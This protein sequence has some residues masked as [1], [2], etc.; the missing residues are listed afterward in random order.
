M[1]DAIAANKRDSL[2][3]GMVQKSQE[4]YSTE[5]EIRK[6]GSRLSQE[7]TKK[8]SNASTSSDD[9]KIFEK[10]FGVRKQ[11]I[12]S[13]CIDTWWLKTIHFF[14]VFI[15][16]YISLMETAAT[17]VFVGYATQSYKQ[18][19]LMA[20]IGVIRAVVVA[21]SL[22]AFAR[23][24]DIFG[25]F[26]IFW[27]G[28][29]L[30]VIGLIIMSQATSVQKY[31]GGIVFYGAGFASARILLQ[32]SA[33][34][35]TT[36]RWRL[37]SNAV[38]SLPVIITTWSSG[39]VVSSLQERYGWHFGIAMWAFTV[40]LCCIPFGLS[41]L[42]AR[43]KAL[44]T[45]EWKLVI[46]EEKAS[47]VEL[48]PHREEYR[49]ALQSK[50]GFFARLPAHLKMCFHFTKYRVIQTFWQVD[51]LGCLLV[52]CMFGFIL[53]P[54]TLA[55]GSLTKWQRGSIIAP[56]VIG[57]CFIPAFIAW[58]M[59]FSR[60]PLIPFPLLRDRGIWAGYGIGVM[61]TF[62]SGI[63]GA[64]A[65]PVLLVGM[66]ATKVVATRTP[67][68]GSFVTS[69]TLPFVA[70]AVLKIKRTKA[71]ILWGCAMLFVSMG[72]FVHFR[73]DNDG[74]KGK[75]FRDGLA[76]AFSIDG[77]GTAFFMRPVGVS[78]QSCTNYEY[79]AT[80]TALFAALYNIG[81]ACAKCV[82]GAIWTQ[83]MYP[84][85]VKKMELLGVNT[86]LAKPAFQ[87]PYK[88]AEKYAWGT[89]PRRAVALAYAELQRKLCIVA[90]C[91]LVPL[92]VFCF[93]LRDHRLE[94]VRSLENF[95]DEEKG[96]SG[97][98]RDK[99]AVIYT[100][101]HDPIMNFMKKIVGMGRKQ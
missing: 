44:R 43:V 28:M 39:N 79:M 97:A 63:P 81:G 72:L 17:N 31:A 59:K 96:K 57:F 73:G 11:E 58:E 22:P 4:S 2:S 18:H 20:T 85:I 9:S 56:L 5:G 101:D 70:V 98:V 1:S 3:D 95:E 93:F 66:N 15:G 27:F 87:Q 32:I 78:M 67:Q 13:D 100:D 24:S 12:Q 33:Q 76:A 61:N 8:P 48:T 53:V 45:P 46:E 62:A 64:F 55:G 42:Y 99:G 91:L 83:Q 41:C 29:V 68:L 16:M 94:D 88:F 47:Q 23:L 77:F 37:F 74:L 89:P 90:I 65:Y 50:T 54:L 92:L 6:E 71:F 82:S 34:D 80:V 52:V 7:L 35:V 86:S 10:S 26:E 25:R 40:P 14:T 60:H 19:S 21:S 36:L 30:R 84:T 69:V 49:R 51:I 38:I 75:Y